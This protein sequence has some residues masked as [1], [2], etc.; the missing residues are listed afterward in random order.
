MADTVEKVNDNTIR[1]VH[2]DVRTDVLTIDSIKQQLASL[3]QQKALSMAR[4]DAIQ[5]LIDD[6]TSVLVT[7]NTTLGMTNAVDSGS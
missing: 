2:T 7:A 3:R 4:C 1:R 6:L 5:K